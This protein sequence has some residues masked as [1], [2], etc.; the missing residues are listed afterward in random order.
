MEG[1]RVATDREDDS[2]DALYDSFADDFLPGQ[3]EEAENGVPLSTA[4]EA[5]V[6]SRRLAA[7]P[8]RERGFRSRVESNIVQARK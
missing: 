4:V 2:W 3:Q 8:Q 1:S 7:D 5:F 6:R